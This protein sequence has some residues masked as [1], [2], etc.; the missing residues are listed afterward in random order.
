[1]FKNI[2][3]NT[4]TSMIHI[5]EQVKGENFYTEIEWCPYVYFPYER[6]DVKTIYGQ[7]VTKR[8]FKTYSDYYSYTKDKK[9]IFE[10]R[11]R[12]EIQFLAERY[13]GIPDEDMDRPK[14]K[15]YF[16]DIEI[17]N[18]IG[19][20]HPEDAKDPIC[21]V[22][23]YDDQTNSTT[24]FGL[25]DYTAGKYFGEKYVRYIKCD[26]E[27][28]L[29][30]RLLN[31]LHKYP[32]DVISGWSI[33]DFDLPYI[34]NRT[35]NI[36]DDPKM[37]M[38]ISPIN[39]VQTWDGKGG[40][41]N[42]NISGV[43]ILDYISLY[44]WYSP[45][46]LERYSLDF[47]SNHELEKGKTDYSKYKDLRELCAKDWNLFVD[48]N[49]TDSLRV[50][51]LNQKLGYIEMVQALSLLTKCPMKYYDTMTQLIEGLMLTH[52]RRTRRCAPQFLGGTQET[53]EAAY[54]KEPQMGKH[55]WVVDLDI[56]SSYPTAII[57]LNMSPETY[58]GRILDMTEDSVVQYVKQKKFPEFLLLKDGRKLRF[59]GP[60]LDIF[61]EAIEKK[62]ISIAPCGSV[63]STKNPGVIADIE[64]QV[65]QKRIL[66][67]DKMIKLKKS[68]PSLRGDNKK[69][70]EEKVGQYQG[71]QNALKIILNAMFGVTSVPYSR[72]F[73]VNIAE[74]ITSCGRQTIK[75]GERYVND[76]LRN[77][78]DNENL[79]SVL[80]E[81]DPNCKCD[82]K[83]KEDFVC[84]IDTDS[85]FIMM[86]KFLEKTVGERWNLLDDERK[87]HFILKLSRVIEDYVNEVCYREVQR[88]M[89]NSNVTDFRIK[90][91]QEMVAKTALFVKKK[92]Y[93]YW[94]VNEEGAPMDKIKVTGL[95]IIRSD[96]PEA[97]RP[98]LKEVMDM[99]LKGET[100]DALV[101]I[102]DQYKKE[103]RKVYPEEIAVNIGASDVDKYVSAAGEIIKGTPFHLKGINN[104]R[105][106]LKHLGLEDKYEDIT[107][108]AKTKVVYLKKNPLNIDV[109]SF[110][111]WPTEFDKVIQIDYEK[112]LEKY[113]IS[114]IE[115]LLEPMKKTDL[116]AGSGG[117]G[118]SLFFGDCK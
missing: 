111:R 81:I 104:Y 52:F 118:L 69:M 48:Y 24:I 102:I 17:D 101:K 57:T 45:T 3:Y 2:Y 40:R 73:N 79:V 76:L 83:Y 61:N 77:Y 55:D 63:F 25:G 106:L 108:G 5:W 33:Y 99:I 8:Q 54:V 56:A 9:E 30:T 47:V 28:I 113:F 35:K 31:F 93:G 64:R 59:A 11:V 21:L 58:Y 6:G 75:S 60:K 100:D 72:Y 36:F 42:I 29:L 15:T 88:K 71:L 115:I 38:R 91:K 46:K 97:I 107:S 13:Y 62:I 116:L 70:A 1:M 4:R 51:Q 105:N 67:K 89:Y 43:T 82:V 44:K 95:E 78:S 20:P 7:S 114:K 110:L 41:A 23:I 109:M 10:D 19:F 98:R 94:A 80:K 103:L 65:F 53:F 117:I 16:L 27:K 96:T 49:I 86:G 22:S 12:P 92:K 74:A 68:L 39:D 66:V 26:N 85:I 18:K 90:F 32:P 50:H 37:F 87:I 84:Y 34:I 112:M 14:L